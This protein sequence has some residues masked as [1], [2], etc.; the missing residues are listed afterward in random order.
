MKILLN[1]DELQFSGNTLADLLVEKSL[2]ENSGIAAAVNET[3][4]SK[5]EWS[6]FRLKEGD[7]VLIIT[8]AQGG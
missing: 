1:D 6:S 2:N 4:I 7:S 3:V 8:P 5:N